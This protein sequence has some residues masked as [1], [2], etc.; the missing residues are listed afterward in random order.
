[1]LKLDE[2]VRR[3]REE[4]LSPSTTVVY[5]NIVSE[6]GKAGRIV[7]ST[8]QIRKWTGLSKPTVISSIKDLIIVKFLKRTRNWTV[9]GWENPSEYEIT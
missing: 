4:R 7:A 6:A 8:S 9:D 5:L 3:C 1:M 2:A